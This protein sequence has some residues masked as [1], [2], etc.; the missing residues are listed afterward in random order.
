MQITTGYTQFIAGYCSGRY[1]AA[2]RYVWDPADTRSPI[3]RSVVQADGWREPLPYTRSVSRGD[4]R[5]VLVYST[6][7]GKY[8]SNTCPPERLLRYQASGYPVAANTSST[9][10]SVPSFPTG[11]TTNLENKALGKLKD[12]GMNLSVAFAER[13]ET[14]SMV[15]NTVQTLVKGFRAARRGD[16]RGIQKILGCRGLRSKPS[17]TAA[18]LWL[19]YQYGWKPLY[20]DVYDGV[21][22][23]LDNDL[24]RP[25]RYMV[26]V[27]AS[28]ESSSLY[29][30][31]R[32]VSLGLS[33][34]RDILHV[35]DTTFKAW[36]RLDYY[37]QNGQLATASQLGITNPL[38]VAWEV[39]PFSFVADW[40]LPVGAALSALDATTG[41]S[42]RGG[43]LSTKR[44]VEARI[45][46]PGYHV[47]NSTTVPYHSG[48]TYVTG[49]YGNRTT[50]H[51]MSFARTV[52]GSSPSANLPRFSENPFST[53]RLLSAT[54]LFRQLVKL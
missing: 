32:P 15:T 16:W 21:S 48:T 14:I 51:N 18:N 1:I 20:S 19:Q 5:T 9:L 54:S 29:K 13:K 25:K 28:A 7:A 38:E 35:R 17:K 27:K 3:R 11:F 41:W 4:P 31:Y 2:N 50:Y 12:R 52:Y 53:T 30:E 33:E 45:E 47:W 40:F 43:S 39:V 8:L 26:T 44:I 22:M 6:A 34:V 46:K 10:Y 24:E 37:L 23:L 49:I 42:F 36:I